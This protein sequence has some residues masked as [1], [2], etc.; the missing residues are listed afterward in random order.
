MQSNNLYQTPGS[1]LTLTQLADFAASMTYLMWHSRRSCLNVTTG[2]EKSYSNSIYGSDMA[3]LM[4][5]VNKSATRAYPLHAMTYTASSAFKRFC[6]QV[7]LAT[8]LKDSAVFLC[9]KYIANLL[10][11]NP[12]VEGA[13]GSEYRLFI[14]AL[15]LANKF[16][17]DHTYTNQSW[18]EVSGMKVED[19]NIMEAEFLVAIDYK[20]FVR[21]QEFAIWKI[22]LDTCRQKYQ[23][24][25]MDSAENRQKAVYNTLNTLGLYDSRQEVTQNQ[26]EKVFQEQVY[27]EKEEI[28]HIARITGLLERSY[29]R[30][31]TFV[32]NRKLQTFLDDICT[33]W[34][35]QQS[36]QPHW[37]HSGQRRL[38]APSQLPITLQPPAVRY[39][40]YSNTIRYA[41]RSRL[42]VTNLSQKSWDPLAYSL[43]CQDLYSNTPANNQYLNARTIPWKN[44]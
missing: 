24:N 15:M 37:D 38:L 7:L 4:Q 39:E 40:G 21:A 14:V 25:P 29:E 33:K 5:Q 42:P 10:Q 3:Y 20:L 30:Y 43:R 8:Q 27:E 44:F 9:L 32:K 34:Q 35:P 17:D 31:V 36:Y 1:A 16:L 11:A 19:L 6:Y 13:E 22:L 41:N 28:D 18:S 26:P 12:R 2:V 23:I